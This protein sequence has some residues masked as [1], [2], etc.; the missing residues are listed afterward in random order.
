MHV[1]LTNQ[2][3]ENILNEQKKIIP[4]SR[5]QYLYIFLL[6][7]LQPLNTPSSKDSFTP[8]SCEN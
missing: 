5:L 3:Q 6:W 4:T 7:L 1:V 2:K 8:S